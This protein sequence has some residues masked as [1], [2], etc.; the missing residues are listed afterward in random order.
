[1]PANSR[2][3]KVLMIPIAKAYAVPS[4]SPSH[5][6]L[7]ADPSVRD[8]GIAG[9]WSINVRNMVLQLVAKQFNDFLRGSVI[10]TGPVFLEER[11][12]RCFFSISFQVCL[13][14]QHPAMF[15]S[16]YLE[17]HC[18]GKVLQFLSTADSPFLGNSAGFFIGKASLLDKESCQV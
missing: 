12:V 5:L 14:I 2:L 3:S 13:P 8:I 16:E 18:G 6:S 15:I 9:N 1:M 4:L 11:L 10:R 17:K 7:R